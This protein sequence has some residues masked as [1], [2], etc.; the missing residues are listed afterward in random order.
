MLLLYAP[1]GWIHR[2]FYLSMNTHFI[3]TSYTFFLVEYGIPEPEH[4]YSEHNE[5]N[6]PVRL[7]PDAGKVAP[8]GIGS[9]P[10]QR[11]KYR[12]ERTKNRSPDSAVIM[13]AKPRGFRPLEK[14]G[15]EKRS[16][17]VVE[18]RWMAEK[19]QSIRGETDSP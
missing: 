6:R 12:E 17:R 5:E 15:D 13:V 18:L 3:S 8:E 19:P 10:Q 2:F 14:S 9:Q 7:H 4:A 16:E 11:I 1:G